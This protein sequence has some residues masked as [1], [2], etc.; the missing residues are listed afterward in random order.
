MKL[1]IDDAIKFGKKELDKAQKAKAEAGETQATA[2]GDL[3]VVSKSLAEDIQQLADTHHD[4]MTKAEDF[5]LE[6]KSR[7]EE[8]KALAEAKK[9]ITEMTGGATSQSYSFLQV[10]AESRIKTRA[11]LANFEAVRH[12]E[13]LARR[14]GSTAL[15]QLAQRMDAAARLSGASGD[16]PFAKVKGL[17][18]DMIERL[19][20]EAEEDAAKKGYCDKEMAETKAKKADLTEEID[21][22]STK[23]DKMSA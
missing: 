18:A 22:L 17:I 11:D 16:D 1:E 7:A 21:K 10:A 9:I 5:E 4:C 13:A 14:L 15:A 12:I 20:K 6:M 23:I 2:E 3:A 8:L 19:L